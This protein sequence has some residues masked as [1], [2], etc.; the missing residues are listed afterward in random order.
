M[1][2][3]YFNVYHAFHKPDNNNNDVPMTLTLQMTRSTMMKRFNLE[4]HKQRNTSI[5]RINYNKRSDSSN[6]HHTQ[7]DSANKHHTQTDSA[8][9]HLTQTDSSNKHHKHTDGS[10]KHHRCIK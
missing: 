1:H 8:N 2:R 4:I 6:T 3:L 7:T 5:S 10:N 9:K